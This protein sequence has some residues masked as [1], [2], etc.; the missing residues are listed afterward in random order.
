VLLD[1]EW[2]AF[3]AWQEAVAARGGRLGE[4]SYPAIIGLEAGATARYI[5]QQ[6]GL[7]FD[8][9]ETCEWTWERVLEQFR[10]GVTPMPGA[11]ALLGRLKKQGCPLAIASNAYSEYIDTALRGLG[12]TDFFPVQVGI[13]RVTR[14]KPAPD[15]YLLAAQ[16]LGVDPA[17]CLVF[18]DSVVGVQAAA[19]AGMRVIAVP[20]RRASRAEFSH[21]WRIYASLEEAGQ[22]LEPMLRCGGLHE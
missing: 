14:G 11:L 2:L 19:S 22:S 17:R 12:M 5:M 6:T 18:E 16:E 20:D 8:V 1:S 13:D 7:T 3:L 4:E 9:Q 10:D 21:A 15:V